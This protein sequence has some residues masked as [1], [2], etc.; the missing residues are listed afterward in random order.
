MIIEV[1]DA[2]LSKEIRNQ[3][4]EYDQENL[5]NLTKLIE[6]LVFFDQDNLFKWYDQVNLVIDTFWPILIRQSDELNLFISI[7]QLY[8]VDLTKS[9]MRVHVNA[10]ILDSYGLFPLL[11]SHLCTVQFL[12]PYGG[13]VFSG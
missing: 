8:L 4:D 1:T 7:D 13:L 9:G 12:V 3:A 11:L 2:D 10:E 6:K 5:V